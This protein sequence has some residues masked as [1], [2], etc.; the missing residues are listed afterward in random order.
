MWTLRCFNTCV[1][2]C[3]LSW[4][5]LNHP[6]EH[7]LSVLIRAN[8]LVNGHLTLMP[9]TQPRPCRGRKFTS[10]T[11]SRREWVRAPQM[12]RAVGFLQKLSTIDGVT[13]TKYLGIPVSR[14]L[15][16]RY[17]IVGHFLIPRI[18]SAHKIYR[19]LSSDVEVCVCLWVYLLSKNVK[20]YAAGSL[21]LRMLTELNSSSIMPISDWQHLLD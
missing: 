20:C 16:G 21:L 12:I 3:S 2:R 15:L 18:P 14:Y 5:E 8:R 6:V 19:H 17:I 11:Y 7:K 9:A 13:V 4:V 10:L 1:H